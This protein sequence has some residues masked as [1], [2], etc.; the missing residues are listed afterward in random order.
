MA[1]RPKSRVRRTKDETPPNWPKLKSRFKTVMKSVQQ[2]IRRSWTHGTR[3]VER[4][5]EARILPSLKRA[6]RKLEGL[7]MALEKRA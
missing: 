6:R 7:I 5:V 2:E 3:K 4:G 1:R